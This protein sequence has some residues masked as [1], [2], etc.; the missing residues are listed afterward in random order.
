MLTCT[1]TRVPV[2]VSQKFKFKKG[3][4]RREGKGRIGDSKT[5]EKCPKI[6]VFHLPTLYMQQNI[7]SFR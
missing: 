3:M 6:Y 4:T 1:K 5:V 7:H 2:I